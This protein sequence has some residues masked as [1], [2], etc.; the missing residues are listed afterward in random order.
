MKSRDF[1]F[2]LQGFFE[3]SS[4]RNLSENQVDMIKAHLNLVFKHDIDPE[5]GDEKTQN[6]LNNIHNPHSNHNLMRC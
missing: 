5:M 2:W 1:A 3:L 4:S 6:E